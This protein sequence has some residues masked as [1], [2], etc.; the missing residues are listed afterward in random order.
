[1]PDEHLGDLLS[2]LVDGELTPDEQVTAQAHLEGCADCRA[3]LAATADTAALLRSLPAVDPRF[4]FYERLLRG[5]RF[6]PDRR[7]QRVGLTVA[8][9][10]AAIALFV[11]LGADLA[12]TE[13]DPA[14]DDMVQAH[15][16]G[17]VPSTGFSAMSADEVDPAAAPAAVAEDFERE[18]VFEGDDVM[19]VAYRDG[20]AEVSVFEQAGELAD[21]ALDP[22]MDP[23]DEVDGLDG[24]EE[25]AWAMEDDGLRVL[26]VDAERVVY[27]VV[28]DAP[29]PVLVAV[30][31]DLPDG[32]DPS[33]LQRARDAGTEVVWTFGLGD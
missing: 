23:M 21:D 30:V 32:P 16:A 18:A 31:A 25:D 29:L 26:V 33:L 2:A 24:M 5:R 8:T 27:T 6:A 17:F 11:A 1:M 9:A 13:V 12:G 22:A 7:R 15:Q 10:A 14:V 19:G 4:G 28:G 20:A 3:E